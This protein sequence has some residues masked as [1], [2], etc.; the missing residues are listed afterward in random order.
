[1]KKIGGKE[2]EGDLA[3]RIL[4]VKRLSLHEDNLT[5][6]FVAV[7]AC[8]LVVVNHLSLFL[9]LTLSVVFVAVTAIVVTVAAFVKGN[10]FAEA[11][12]KKRLLA[13]QGEERHAFPL[14]L[15][16]SQRPLL[17]HDFWARTEAFGL[18]LDS[19]GFKNGLVSL[20]E[21]ETNTKLQHIYIN[22]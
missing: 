19:L 18:A 11:V 8:A 5:R 6:L 16:L 20:K 17:L 3:E 13:S 10:P 12:N 22:K 7:L 21:K 15:A 2:K 4:V 14:I 1:M 9:K